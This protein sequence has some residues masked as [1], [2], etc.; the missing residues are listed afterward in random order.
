M[1]PSM[2]G[3][4]STT[5]LRPLRRHYV[6]EECVIEMQ[7]AQL[8]GGRGD[9]RALDWHRLD[10]RRE[11]VP[12][13]L[14]GERIIDLLGDPWRRGRRAGPEQQHDIAVVDLAVKLAL[15]AVAGLEVQ[16]VL[17]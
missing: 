9:R 6:R 15:P 3:G 13:L 16:H 14:A 11:I 1:P 12:P 17:E 5:L 8:F 2:M 10:V 7:V 4:R